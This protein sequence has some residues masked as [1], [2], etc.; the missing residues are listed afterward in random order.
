MRQTAAA[1]QGVFYGI[2][3]ALK[4]FFFNTDIKLK[5]RTKKERPDNMS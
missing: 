3:F 2:G 1:G 5:P 4:T